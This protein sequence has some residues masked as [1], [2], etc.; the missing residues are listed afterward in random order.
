MTGAEVEA[1]LDALFVGRH[2]HVVHPSRF[3]GD[4]MIAVM[5]TDLEGGD[6]REVALDRLPADDAEFDELSKLLAG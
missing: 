5:S 6:V 3:R 2:H 1:A 4:G